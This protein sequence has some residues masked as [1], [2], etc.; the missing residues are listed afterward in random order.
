[1]QHAEEGVF[2]CDVCSCDP[3]TKDAGYPRWVIPE[4][5]Y[6]SSRC[7][8]YEVNER[9]VFLLRLYNH[10][11]NNHLPDAGGWFNQSNVFVTAVELIENHLA[12]SARRK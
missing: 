1:M 7:L 9:S 3:V 8:R 11:K 2:N 4:I 12:V 6:E 10:Y 5:G